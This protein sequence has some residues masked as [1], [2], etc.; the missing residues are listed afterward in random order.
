[1]SLVLPYKDIQAVEVEEDLLNFVITIRTEE[2]TIRLT[3]QQKAYPASRA[4]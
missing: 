4:Y 3:T 1:M 2:D